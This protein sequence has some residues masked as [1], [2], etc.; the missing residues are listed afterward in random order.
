[1]SSAT[2]DARRHRPISWVGIA[3][4]AFAVAL[5]PLRASSQ[6]APII[7]AGP[8][9]AG[10]WAFEQQTRERWMHGREQSRFAPFHS[11]RRWILVDSIRGGEP[12]PRL[13]LTLGRSV[14]GRDSAIIVVDP[15][16]HIAGLEVG[17]APFTR[18]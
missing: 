5:V 11:D 12:G 3:L 14:Y 4:A 10:E 2:H 9:L 6:S 17:I 1:M 7:F 15:S 13:Y 18:R 8:T 16:G